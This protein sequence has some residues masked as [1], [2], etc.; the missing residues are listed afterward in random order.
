MSDNVYPCSECG[1]IP[2]LVDGST[3]YPHRPDLG[4]SKFYLCECGAYVGC[5][6][7]TSNALGSP[8]GYELRK[9]RS[10]CHELFDPLWKRKQAKGFS[11]FE[12]RS[13]AYRWLA[14]EMSIEL[15]SCHFSQFNLE[16][17][18]AALKI[19]D[20]WIKYKK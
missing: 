19:L 7:G 17:C 10:R 16:Q 20:P 11:K 8:A 9:A 1:S 3:I 12:A 13:A 14:G 6:K 15:D 2:N 5:H 4:S 18:N